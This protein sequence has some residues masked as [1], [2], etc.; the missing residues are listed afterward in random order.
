MNDEQKPWALVDYDGTVGGIEIDG[1]Y[2]VFREAYFDVKRQLAQIC[3]DRLGYSAETT[4]KLFDEIDLKAIHREGFSNKKRFANSVVKTFRALAIGDESE[5]YAKRPDILKEMFDLGMSVFEYPHIPV[6]GA[7]DVLSALSTKYQLAIVTKGEYET[8]MRKIVESG[9][10][11][12]AKEVIVVSKKDQADWDHVFTTLRIPQEIRQRC[13]AIGDSIK[14]DVNI[15]VQMGCNGVHI[16][17][18]KQWEFEVAE[19]AVPIPPAQ[20]HVVSDIR[21]VL[22]FI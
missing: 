10:L 16:Y 6:P 18:P 22:K 19:P 20:L 15:P 12:Y 2:A 1:K 8:Q 7:I 9:V 21:D 17:D 13:W 3:M 5:G 11:P 4:I 14:S